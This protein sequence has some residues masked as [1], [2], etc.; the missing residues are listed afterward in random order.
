VSG[1]AA[2]PR[3][4]GRI[5]ADREFIATRFPAR[6][7][8]GREWLFD[9]AGN[10][11][12]ARRQT[13][14]VGEPGAGKS[15]F[16][17]RVAE[18]W[19]CP[20][21]FVRADNMSGVSG[22]D[23]RSFLVRI[24]AQLREKYGPGIFQRAIKGST[25]VKVG[26]AGDQAKVTGRVIDE[27]YQLP[28]LEYERDVKVRVGAATSGAVVYGERI[29][30]VY[31]LSL[32]LEPRTLLHA[33]VLWPL[34]QLCSLYPE[35]R[36]VL[37]ID[38][39]DETR[40][41]GGLLDV[42]PRTSDAA[43][44]RN[45]A[46]LMTSRPGSHLAVFPADDLI[47]L[48]SDP[49]RED[50]RRDTLAYIQ[51]RAGEEPLRNA[52]ES[53]DGERHRQWTSRVAEDSQDNAL[54]LYH[55]F[56]EAAQAV[57][58][59]DRQLSRL[60]VP[61][62]LDE[63]YR[64]FAVN[65]I[66]RG[67]SDTL[68]L[69]ANAPP[70]EGMDDR[71]YALPGVQSVAV[72]GTRVTIL[73]DDANAVLNAVLVSGFPIAGV[74][75]HQGAASGLWEETYLP[76]LGVLAVCGEPLERETI[77]NFARVQVEF[78]DSVL[79]QIEQFLRERDR[80][81]R[82]YHPSFADYLLDAARNRD[83]P[84]AG[85]ASHRQVAVFYG[86]QQLEQVAV[87]PFAPADEYAHR[88][89]SVHLL[90][91]EEHDALFALVDNRG[92]YEGQRSRNPSQAQYLN[93]LDQARH[94]AETEDE[95]AITRGEHAPLLDRE[96]WCT[97]A[98][99][100][101][102]SL[103]LQTP[104]ELLALAIDTGLWSASWALTAARQ[105]PEKFLR[106]PALLTV[107]ARLDKGERERV[108][109][110]ALEQAFEDRSNLA[111]YLTELA[112]YAR[113]LSEQ[114]LQKLLE[115][116]RSSGDP[117]ERARQLEELAA[118][119]PADWQ[120]DLTAEITAA[121]RELK[122]PEERAAS[123]PDGREK[124]AAIRELAMGTESRSRMIS[125]FYSR[126][127]I[128][129]EEA[130]EALAA[131]LAVPWVDEPKG[132]FHSNQARGRA[133]TA[134]V[135]ILSG[136][137]LQTA[138]LAS[139]ELGEP[140]R[141]Y[142]LAAAAKRLAETG[143]PTEGIELTQEIKDDFEAV[144]SLAEIGEKLVDEAESSACLNASVRSGDAQHP[145]V[146]WILAVR[147]AELGRSDRA[148][149]LA[150]SIESP[151]HKANALAGA[152]AALR[153]PPDKELVHEALRVSAEPA[154]QDMLSDS[155]EQ[156]PL[157][158]MALRLARDR[159][160]EE[161]LASA[162][163]FPT[164]AEALTTVASVLPAE[165]RK[166]VA[167]EALAAGQRI[168]DGRAKIET[169]LRCLGN[170]RPPVV[171]LDALL[172][173]TLKE[174][175][176]LDSRDCATAVAAI[177]P[178]LPDNL[179][180]R[181]IEAA[182]EIED[183]NWRLHALAKLCKALPELASGGLESEVTQL[184]ESEGWSSDR[185]DGFCTF[186][187]LLDAKDQRAVLPGMSEFPRGIARVGPLLSEEVQC[188]AVAVARAF[189]NPRD[190]VIALSGLAPVLSE[191]VQREVLGLI[192]EEIA[193]MK[194]DPAPSRVKAIKEHVRRMWGAEN[195]VDLLPIFLGHLVGA[196]VSD[197]IA[198]AREIE[199]GRERA[200]VLGDIGFR[201]T[202]LGRLD[203]ALE[204]AVELDW[205]ESNRSGTI[206]SLRAAIVFGVLVEMPDSRRRPLVRALLREMRQIPTQAARGYALA[207]LVPFVEG[208]RRAALFRVVLGCA[209]RGGS[210]EERAA[211]FGVL[212]L[213]MPPELAQETREALERAFR[214]IYIEDRVRAV[215][216]KDLAE[217][218]A[219]IPMAKI[220][221]LWRNSVPALAARQRES[222]IADLPSL[223]AWLFKLG[224]D[225]MATAVA[226]AVADVG[227][228]WP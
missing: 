107:A 118:F 169:I 86:G 161:A 121:A 16:V 112:P 181:A 66:R 165:M 95:A 185:L 93:D 78:V 213:A 17:A 129:E 148:I 14:L 45:L 132:S 193:A 27:L 171:D 60:P 195:P 80:R 130:E 141:N 180:D 183:T 110:E 61:K 101:V 2:D 173:D 117:S 75:I 214:E 155:S 104:V 38:A 40:Q 67:L 83:F 124:L 191:E 147:L 5:S 18:S 111:N 57:R 189:E 122:D 97:L 102:R 219:S 157:M 224:G 211:V 228:R 41:G 164:R 187:A 188:E 134:V 199:D 179:R 186:V 48:D 209:N 218:T 36:V 71:L 154:V 72:E 73:C 196:A 159:R 220:Y 23:A 178:M 105:Y 12:S 120:D 170:Y 32:A 144:K 21:H 54:Y 99:S 204:L 44:P 126:R 49:Y 131:S 119:A 140:D 202:A 175:Q 77:A 138:I 128:S 223:L 87:E 149:A 53:W 150:R 205:A 28:F 13:I 125:E 206:P 106:F 135:R 22:T 168:G 92:W 3:A 25:E 163:S 51:R 160:F 156:T 123:L 113:I 64:F 176:Q 225:W 172:T 207:T 227:R 59:G 142:A 6:E 43:F 127:D 145:W 208:W 10:V 201:M 210:A 55:F 133:L 39:L 174:I 166:E 65:R 1:L 89:L 50:R 74:E 100:S 167:K 33:A 137:F 24:G 221:A 184:A 108:V 46:L 29:H 20:R 192:R 47:E 68:R 143:S 212:L 197:A 217:R 11:R 4:F 30:K 151:W 96:V 203:E 116:I 62:G 162:R 222:A 194:P 58:A 109:R 114:D 200:P 35:E 215:L 26:W 153:E 146:R 136:R 177:G 7:F 190:R 82:F 37:V 19:N 76:V 198:L 182:R 226:Q 91:A 42:I 31:D 216:L 84:I 52:F 103:F 69:T 56:N 98:A 85:R 79:A 90:H 152:A 139:R 8:V 158:R 15:T 70:V 115:A 81:W 9:L 34:E 63:I 94:A 88:H